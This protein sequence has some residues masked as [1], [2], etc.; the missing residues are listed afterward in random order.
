[1]INILKKAGLIAAGCVVAVVMLE[2]I[3]RFIPSYRF[4]AMT[5]VNI[6]GDQNSGTHRYRASPM[7]GFELVPLSRPDVNSFGMRDKEYTLKKPKGVYRI[8]LLGD[9]ICEY[10]RWSDQVEA[11]LN[12]H[13][14]Y[15]LLN[16]ATGGW[17]LTQYY[18][19]LKEKGMRFDP[20]LVLVALCLNDIR[21]KDTPIMLTEK[22][23]DKKLIYSALTARGR[24]RVISLDINSYLFRHSTLYR[25]MAATY[26]MVGNIGAGGK[27]NT[28]LE[29]KVRSHGKIMAVIFPYLKPLDQYSRSEQLDYRTMLRSLEGLKIDYL[30]LTPYFNGY[31]DKISDFRC[32]AKDQ[33]HYNDEA[34]KLKA[35]L[36]FDWL[37]KEIGVRDFQQGNKPH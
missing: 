1:M 7:F 12:E 30:D 20:D 24:S 28:F 13:G 11:M 18:L 33:I 8:L 5:H 29:M 15:E 10:G 25:F 31:G 2:I 3:L 9:S 17:G 34:N 37:I 4:E 23:L 36:I 14:K 26:F 19:Y 6:Q 16:C 35:K 22:K 27:E 21:H 32:N